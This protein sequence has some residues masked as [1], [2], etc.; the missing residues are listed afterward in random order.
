[1]GRLNQAM[2]YGSL[3]TTI[4]AHQFQ[5]VFTMKTPKA[6]LDFDTANSRF[7]PYRHACTQKFTDHS[8]DLLPT[9]LKTLQAI[10]NTSKNAESKPIATKQR[11][12]K[13]I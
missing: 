9:D 4:A 6:C 5:T 12:S 1:M 10:R 8:A 3:L 13:P 11:I 7:R 2:A